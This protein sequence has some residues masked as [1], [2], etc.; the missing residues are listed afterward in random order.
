M[1]LHIGNSLFVSLLV[2]SMHLN[3]FWHYFNIQNLN[4]ASVEDSNFDPKLNNIM[5]NTRNW[6]FSFPGEN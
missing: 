4:Q 1:N 2:Y 5:V 3:V 6:V